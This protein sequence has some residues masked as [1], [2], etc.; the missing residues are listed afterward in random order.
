MAI[1]GRPFLKIKNMNIFDKI[2]YFMG[3]IFGWWRHKITTTTSTTISTTS[4]TRTTTSTS[5]TTILPTTTS[6]STTTRPLTTTTSST[7]TSTLTT[8]TTTKPPTTTTTSTTTS[9]TTS[10]STTTKIPV[11]T[12]TTTQTSTTS[13][14]TTTRPPVTTSTTT[15]TSTTSTSTTTRPPTTTSTS[16]TTATPAGRHNLIFTST[17]EEAD[18]FAPWHNTQ[19]CCSYSFTKNTGEVLARVG[20]YVGRVELFKTDPTVAASKRSEINENTS[21]PLNAERWVG[22]SYYFP[23]ATYTYDLDPELIMQWHTDAPTG[24][25]P[26]SLNTWKGTMYVDQAIDPAGGATQD[27]KYFQQTTIM[28]T[29]LYDQWIDVVVHYRQRTDSTGLVEVWVNGNK[30]YTKAGPCNF[31]YQNYFKIGI[32]KWTWMP[33]ASWGGNQT[34]R[35]FYID[36]LRLGNELATYTDVSPGAY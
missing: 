7:S 14:S 36:E 13:T 10:T 26:F 18:P 8:T 25:P 16:T 34:H 28:N 9:S 2:T 22:V 27:N 17:F 12:S 20:N 19:H 23:S 21:E 29:L 6:T 1:N 32:N 33:G 24:S 4:T 31:N 35:L 15:Q 11:T 5:T 30:V 3:R